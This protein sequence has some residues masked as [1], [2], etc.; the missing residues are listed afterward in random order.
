[1]HLKVFCEYV[2]SYLKNYKL[3]IFK[4]PLNH[5]TYKDMIYNEKIVFII[6]F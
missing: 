4:I 6:I 5:T 2:P 3:L 1:M